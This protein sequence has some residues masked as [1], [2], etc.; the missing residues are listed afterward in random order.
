MTEPKNRM[1]ARQLRKTIDASMSR[2]YG[3]T[4]LGLSICRHLARLMGGEV[5]VISEEGKGS[6]FWL[7]VPLDEHEASATGEGKTLT[8]VPPGLKVL[9]A[10]DNEF[11]QK[12]AVH[13]LSGMGMEVDLAVNGSQ[14]LE[15]ALQTPYDIIFMDCQMPEM[16]GLEASVAI[17]KAETQRHSPIIAL[18]ANA[19]E[20][21]RQRCLAAGMDDFVSKPVNKQRL[22]EAICRVLAA[23]GAPPS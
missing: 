2:R 8:D 22:R 21:D 9:L 5:G 14:A 20:S 23:A 4:G 10:E 18:T 12:V 15:K 16:D 3:G 11:N 17:R 7:E 13:I 1:L 6:T 19:F